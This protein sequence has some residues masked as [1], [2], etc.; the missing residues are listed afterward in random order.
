MSGSE[1]SASGVACS[2]IGFRYGARTALIDVSLEARPGSVV[3]LIGPNG[4][5]KTTLIRLLTTVLPLQT[6]TFR[7]AGCEHT[8]PLA[9][10]RRIGVLPE[11]GGFPR[12]TTA[13]DYLMFFA[14]LYGCDRTEAAVRS[15]RLLS[16][17]GLDDRGDDRIKTYSRG[18]RQRLGL[19]RALVN[20]PIVL[21][22]DEPTLGLDPAG[23]ALILR[24]IADA[25]ARRGVT[26]V[27]TSHL[28][29]EVERVC[30]EIVVIDKGRVIGQGAVADVTRGESA[31]GSLRDAFL[32]LTQD[33]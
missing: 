29:E 33:E 6:G 19:A 8:D 28:L 22:L 14:R 24:A 25:A 3:G 12:N 13:A 17:V 5:G 26:V 18:M 4:A 1:R 9:I 10:K 16:D 11:S 2:G 31:P 30:E 15:A 21:F 27:L 20:D 7:V 23:Q 32:R